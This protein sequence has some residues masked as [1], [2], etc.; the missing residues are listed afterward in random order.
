MEQ[1]MKSTLLEENIAT[2][3]ND[4]NDVVVEETNAVEVV[5]SHEQVSFNIEK[6]QKKQKVQNIFKNIFVYLFLTI[7]AALAFLPFFWMFVT[8]VKDEASYREPTA[9]FFPDRVMWENY[10]VV[11]SQTGNNGA[12]FT[13]ILVNCFK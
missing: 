7:C 2:P 11:F 13:Q 3:E 1:D 5:D 6:E 8:S 12:N 4:T 9:A 10:E